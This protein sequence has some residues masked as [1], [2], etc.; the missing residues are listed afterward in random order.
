MAPYSKLFHCAIWGTVAM[1]AL[2]W[3]PPHPESKEEWESVHDMR[4]RLGISYNYTPQQLHP[5]MCRFLSEEDCIDHD[6]AMGQ[7]VQSHRRIQQQVRLSPKLG[8][9]NV[10]VVLARFTDHTDRDMIPVRD[11]RDFWLVN[12][13]DWFRANS[14]GR[15]DIEPTVID[16]QTTDNTEVYYSMG[17]RGIVPESQQIAWPILD[18]LDARPGWDWSKFDADGNGEIDSFVIMHSGYG[19]ETFETDC[20][21]TT[22]ENRIWAHA[23]S[24]SRRGDSWFSA[25]RKIRLN[26]YTVSS[27]FDAECGTVPAKIGLTAH[28]YM[29]TLG[30]EDLYDGVDALAASGVGAFDIMA[31]PYGPADDANNPGHLSPWSKVLA[32][33]LEPVEITSNG[34]YN[35]KAAELSDEAYRINLNDFGSQSE[36]LLIENRQPL[37]FDIHIWGAGLVIYHI[38]DAAPLQMN[39]GYPGQPGWPQNGNHYQVAVLQKDGNYDLEQGENSGDAGDMWLPGD[40]LGPGMGG[41]VYPNTDTYQGGIIMETGLTIEVLRQEGTDVTFR[42]GGLDEVES[43][44]SPT[45]SPTRAVASETPNPTEQSVET[46]VPATPESPETLPPTPTPPLGSVTTQPTETPYLDQFRPYAE[47]PTIAPPSTERPTIPV[48]PPST[49]RP[50]TERPSTP[51]LSSFGSALEI[52]ATPRPQPANGLP[53]PSESPPPQSSFL[54]TFDVFANLRDGGNGSYTKDTQD[55]SF[56]FTNYASVTRTSGGKDKPSEDS[57]GGERM[58]KEPLASTAIDAH[59]TDTQAEQTTAFE[60]T[61]EIQGMSSSSRRM[62]GGEAACTAAWVSTVTFAFIHLVA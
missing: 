10:L 60:S 47:R 50:G 4:R 13:R 35:L 36:Y 34:M 32:D 46:P 24:A 19:A 28:E 44:P 3:I 26:A 51:Y 48:A 18:E 25:D 57:K 33:W 1:G 49:E 2:A 59:E 42:I 61:K 8:K 52:V 38:D 15:Y 37:L 27:A 58:G 14:Q 30:L 5:E 7:H 56:I 17:K 40:K 16:W 22:Y 11:I 45:A 55:T 54:S 9:I 6:E 43:V 53:Q 39:R 41:T 62:R 23:F 31:F 29:H 12:M 20:Y 21:G